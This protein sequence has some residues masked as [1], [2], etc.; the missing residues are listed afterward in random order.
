MLLITGNLDFI[1]LRRCIQF[2]FSPFWIRIRC[3]DIFDPLS[4]S[5]CIR[6]KFHF[7]CLAAAVPLRLGIVVHFSTYQDWRNRTLCILSDDDTFFIADEDRRC[8]RIIRIQHHCTEAILPLPV[9]IDGEPSGLRRCPGILDVR[10]VAGK[11]NTVCV[12]FL[13]LECQIGRLDST[14]R[15]AQY[16]LDMLTRPLSG[17]V[18][19]LCL[20]LTDEGLHLQ[21]RSHIVHIRDG[22]LLYRTYILSV[23][24]CIRNRFHCEFSV[25]W[26]TDRIYLHIRTR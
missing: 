23:M 13:I 15:I 6:N 26:N 17:G 10:P 12:I 24:L 4:Q 5:G 8:C 11:L 25:F 1:V 21:L 16:D 22:Q 2:C 14:F 19:V 3:I 20:I 18:S 9:S 7:Q